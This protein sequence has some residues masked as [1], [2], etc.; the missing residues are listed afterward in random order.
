MRFKSTIFGSLIADKF[1]VLE[2][3]PLELRLDVATGNVGY[4]KERCC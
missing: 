3:Y 1:V 2:K 4:G